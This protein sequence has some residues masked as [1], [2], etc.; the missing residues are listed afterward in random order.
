MVV[1]EV[2]GLFTVSE[3]QHAHHAVQ[4]KGGGPLCAHG[5]RDIECPESILADLKGEVNHHRLKGSVATGPQ[6]DWLAWGTGLLM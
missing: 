5:V 4:G 1:E 6:N 2:C 3:E